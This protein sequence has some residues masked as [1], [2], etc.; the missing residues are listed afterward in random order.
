MK[1]LAGNAVDHFTYP[2]GSQTHEGRSVTREE[3]FEIKSGD[4]TQ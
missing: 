2:G 1:F 3:S 4:D